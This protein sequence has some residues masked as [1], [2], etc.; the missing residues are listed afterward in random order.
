MKLNADELNSARQHL[1]KKVVDYFIVK[2]GIEALFVQGSIASG[3]TDEFSDIDFRVVV[4]PELY[5]QFLDE[6][7][8]AP[9]YWGEW[10]Y[11]EWPAGIRWV[12][13]SHFHPF[14]KIDVLYYQ[15]ENLQPSPWYLQPVQVI[16]D[17]KKLI[18]QLIEASSGLEFTLDVNEVNRL[19]SKGLAQAEE[20]YR[21]VMRGELFYAQSLLD[22][23]R[24][25]MMQIDDYFLKNPSSSMSPSAHFEQRGSQMLIEVLKHSYPSLDQTSILNALNALLNR[26]QYQVMNLHDM[27]RLNRD[28]KTD[29]HWINTLINLS[30]GTFKF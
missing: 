30:G 9:K 6:R 27:L 20:V 15:P 24:G 23:F 4:Q 13:V 2:K 14:N 1:L 18:H 21:R 5:E 12:C 3:T 17:P 16:Y 19:I 10:L 25:S 7:F 28:A 11:N 22:N 8:S 26:Y 29:L